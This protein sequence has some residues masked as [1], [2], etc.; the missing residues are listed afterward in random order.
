MVGAGL[1]GGFNLV[2]LFDAVFTSRCWFRCIQAGLWVRTTV[3][4]KVRPLPEGI[5][6]MGAYLDQV[7]SFGLGNEWLQLGRSERV[8]EA[9]F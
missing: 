8:H 1:L 6:D 5:A 2:I 7:F 4:I 9:G 3:S